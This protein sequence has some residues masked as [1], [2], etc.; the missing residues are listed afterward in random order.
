MLLFITG[1]TSS[2]SGE[3][4]EGLDFPVQNIADL[5]KFYCFGLQPW[6]TTGNNE[7]HGGIDLV[8]PE[9]VDPHVIV[10]VPI[11]APAA[12]FPN[13]YG[14]VVADSGIFCNEYDY[15]QHYWRDC[16]C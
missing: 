10:R 9:N 16:R 3:A 11:V 4:V 5:E 7:I 13:L 12:A 2:G 15:R 1:C 6:D 8:S 14:P